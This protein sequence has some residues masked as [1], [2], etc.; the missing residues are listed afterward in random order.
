MPNLHVIDHPLIADKLTW[1]RATSTGRRAFRA[2]VNQIAGLMVYE[3]TRNLRVGPVSVETP[4]ERMQGQR[5]VGS[6]TVVPIL[7]AGLGMVTGVLE[8]LPTAR[9]GHLG[10]SRDETTLEP[11]SYLSTLPDDL[12]AGPVLLLDPMLAT[13][14]SASAAATMLRTHGSEDL[15]MLCL[16]AAPEGVQ[17]ML[18]DHPDVPIYTAG[19]DSHL[20]EQGYI[21]P[22][23][24]DAGDRLFGTGAWNDTSESP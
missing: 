14:G 18:K 24:G 21:R 5:L 3:A 13:G 23:L 20:D 10:M 1:L 15:R 11:R 8:M 22:G 9:I 19:L 17:K 16:V 12:N 4:L 2:L 7:R 6:P